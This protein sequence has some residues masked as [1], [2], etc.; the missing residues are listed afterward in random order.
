MRKERE[1]GRHEGNRHRLDLN[2]GPRRRGINLEV[3]VCLLYPNQTNVDCR[4]S[5]NG[6]PSQT[7]DFH[8]N[9]LR[10]LRY[11]NISRLTLFLLRDD[12]II[13]TAVRGIIKIKVV[14]GKTTHAPRTRGEFP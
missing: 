5:V 1:G 6:R 11:N 8:P 12:K 3:Y 13:C 10:L 14:S 7:P 9:I 4:H 2:P